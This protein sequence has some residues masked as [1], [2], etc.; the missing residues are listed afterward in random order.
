MKHS[1]IKQ[2]SLYLLPLVFFGTTKLF[3]QAQ[4][5]QD[6]FEPKGYKDT[7]CRISWFRDT[8]LEDLRSYAFMLREQN[9]IKDIS[10]NESGDT[11]L[12]YAILGSDSV[13]KLDAFIVLL[14][15]DISDLVLHRNNWGDNAITMASDRFHLAQRAII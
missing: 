1:L 12:F 9:G 5:P 13:E 6:N 8:S 14:G 10:C 2:V 11:P 15:L 4:I 3:A 7:V